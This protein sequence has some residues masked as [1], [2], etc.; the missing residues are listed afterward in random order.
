MLQ[1]LEQVVPVDLTNV[2]AERLNTQFVLVDS[3]DLGR[4]QTGVKWFNR[5]T[6]IL[7]ALAFAALARGRAASQ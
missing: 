4:V 3:K 1:K 2:D 6:Y 5:G 7:L